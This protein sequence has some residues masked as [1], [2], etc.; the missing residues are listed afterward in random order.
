MDPDFQRDIAMKVNELGRHSEPPPGA[1]FRRG[2]DGQFH[3]CNPDQCAL[4]SALMQSSSSALTASTFLTSVT[5]QATTS[6]RP[7]DVRSAQTEASPTTQATKRKR[8]IV[9]AS[10]IMPSHTDMNQND[11]GSPGQPSPTMTRSR[12]DS[13][14]SQTTALTEG[15]II[16][17][18]R[19][20]DAPAID[21][22]ANT[23]RSTAILNEPAEAAGMLRL[24]TPSC[25]VALHED[26]LLRMSPRRKSILINLRGVPTPTNDKTLLIETQK[27]VKYLEEECALLKYRVKTSAYVK[28]AC[29]DPSQAAHCYGC[30]RPA[31]VS[32]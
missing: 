29:P 13:S 9:S 30:R 16:S 28:S 7:S 20:D 26:S 27:R 22:S 18:H 24:A 5:S 6:D 32:H 3:L 14:T 15:D 2:S 12:A 8:H 23:S 25:P 4:T 19:P 17:I 10:K 1:M 11:N 21:H 31:A